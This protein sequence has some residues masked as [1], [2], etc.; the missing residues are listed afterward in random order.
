MSDF[1]SESLSDLDRNA[2][3]KWIGIGVRIK[4]ESLSDLPRNTQHL[5]KALPASL[6]GR[7]AV[8]TDSEIPKHALGTVASLVV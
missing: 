2:C 4:L 5:E 3:P 7:S 8:F 6:I 1:K